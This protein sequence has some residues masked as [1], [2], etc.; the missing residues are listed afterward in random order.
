M[1][2]LLEA[3]LTGL[4]GAFIGLIG[5][6]VG[7]SALVA[8]PLLMLLGMSPLVAVATNK[9][10]TLGSSVSAAIAFRQRGIA[11]VRLLLMVAPGAVIGSLIGA[12]LAFEIDPSIFRYVVIALLLVTLIIAV[13][14]NTVAD[15]RPHSIYRPW[16]TILAVFA[17]SVY[18]GCFGVGFGAFLV[19]ALVYCAGLSFVRSSALM[20][21]IYIIVGPAGIIPYALRDAIDYRIGVPLFI[22]GIVGGWL[23]A[24]LAVLRGSKLL[25]KLYIAI[26]G[27]LTLK[28]VVEL[29]TSG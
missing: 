19:F 10:G 6:T 28:L 4:A 11:D 24:R 2:P 17:L 18:S 1:M 29:I 8:L 21:A 3:L 5:A 20:N 27:I 16:A 23:G 9:L 26:T 7:G 22:G 14:A 12:T 15:D 13:R 25:R